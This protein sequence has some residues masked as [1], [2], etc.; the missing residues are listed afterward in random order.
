M[1]IPWKTYEMRRGVTLE[2]FVKNR[3][4]STYE[5]FLACTRPHS[6]YPPHRDKVE[7][8]IAE[9]RSEKQ[10]EI[11]KYK[12][13]GDAISLSSSEKYLLDVEASAEAGTYLDLQNDESLDKMSNDTDDAPEEEVEEAVEDVEEIL[14]DE[15][16]DQA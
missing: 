2:S 13:E 4:I 5:E 3:N 9:A 10:A 14:A 16:E 6:I 8:A 15:E 11:D 1:S 7:A 12:N